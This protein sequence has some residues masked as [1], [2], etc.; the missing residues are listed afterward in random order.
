MRTFHTGFQGRGSAPDLKVVF[1]DLEPEPPQ[2][3]DPILDLTLMFWPQRAIEAA[4]DSGLIL[5]RELIDVVQRNLN[6]NFSLLKR[7]A[8]ARSLGEIVELQASHLSNQVAALIG[9]SEELT[10]LSVKTT[11]EFVRRAYPSR[12]SQDE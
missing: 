9:Q 5:N 8:A 12:Q 7:L 1:K 6:A 11:M 10:A 2:A 3:A 4:T